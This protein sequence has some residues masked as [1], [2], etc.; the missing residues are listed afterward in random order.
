MTTKVLNI[1]GQLNITAKRGSTMPR[2]LCNGSSGQLII[3]RVL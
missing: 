3:S 1:D 2:K